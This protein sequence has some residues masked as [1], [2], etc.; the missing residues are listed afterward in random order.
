MK[1][2]TIDVPEETNEVEVKMAVAA[3]LFDKGVITAGQAAL[4][5]GVTKREFIEQVGKYGI[6]IFGETEEDLKAGLDV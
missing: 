6:S 4:S 2:L 1:T 5:V 3:V